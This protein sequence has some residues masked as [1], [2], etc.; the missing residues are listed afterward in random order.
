VLAAEVRR[1]LAHGIT[2]AHDPYVSPAAHERMVALRADGPI[3]LSWATGSPAGMHSRP[4]GPAS[5]PAGPYGDAGPEV[6]VFADGPD[7]C[8]VRLP[9][10]AVLDLVAGA[11]GQ[12]WRMRAAGPLREGLRR[13]L[14]LRPLHV[15]LPYLRYTDDELAALVAGYAE[16]G[17]RLRIHA[18]GNLAGEQAA[19]ILRSVGVPPGGATIDHLLLLDP[20]T[21]DLV[22]ASGATASNQRGFLRGYGDMIAGTR[23]D[24]RLT[25]FGARLLLRAGVPLVI[26]SDYPCGP[27]DPLHN[28]R[29]AG[30]RRLPSGRQLQADQ[31][32][33]PAEAVRA[34]TV[35]AA[36]SLG[37]AAAGGLAPGQP[38]DLAVCDGDPFQPDTRGRRRTWVAGR[39]V[40]PPQTTPHAA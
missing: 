7:R 11:A 8:A 23:M 6:K 16:A 14:V 19:R 39:P 12:A 18:L 34:H 9:S 37:A 17:M 13:R 5:A 26:S 40:W 1:C 36:A 31:A 2:H 29:A 3:R 24:R 21:A 10:R 28:L 38:A 4:P 27:L 35:T 20:A 30:H 22:A 32:L 15:H 33:T 25:V